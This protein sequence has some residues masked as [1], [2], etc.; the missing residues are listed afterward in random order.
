MLLLS[1][2]SSTKTGSSYFSMPTSLEWENEV[3]EKVAGKT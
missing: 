3:K 2:F 1:S